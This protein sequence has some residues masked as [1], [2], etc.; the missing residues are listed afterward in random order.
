MFAPEAQILEPVNPLLTSEQID[1]KEAVIDDFEKA[2]REGQYLAN[3]SSI[4]IQV[5]HCKSAFQ[6]HNQEAKRKLSRKLK[7]KKGSSLIRPS[8]KPNLTTAV[9]KPS[10]GIDGLRCTT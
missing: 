8:H 1:L 7:N 2:V 5:I 9:H 10:V 4:H 3:K 6:L